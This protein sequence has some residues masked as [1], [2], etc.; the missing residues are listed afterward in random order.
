MAD[1][2]P[3][4]PRP[5]AGAAE[6]PLAEKPL[7]PLEADFSPP[8]P[9]EHAPPHPAAD[10][11]AAEEDPYHQ[12]SLAAKAAFDE[13]IAAV[14]QGKQEQA[15]HRFLKAS[16][17]A[18]SAREWY[19]AAVSFERIGDYF[20]LPAPSHDL[21]RALRMYQR[22]VA[23]YEHCGMF[24]EARELAYR[25]LCIKLWR[26]KELNLA[27]AQ[28]LE[29]FLYWA[30]AGFGLRPL[31]VVVLAVLL[32]VLYGGL[33]WVLDGAVTVQP[34]GQALPLWHA[35]Y[36]SGITFATVGYGDFIPAPHTRFLALTEGLIGAFTMSFFVVVLAHRLSKG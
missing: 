28:R 16:K 33:Y 35:I 25:V 23:A 4:E 30:V 7:G 19:L 1:S 36:F 3:S 29:H 15:A 31:R 26:G 11:S 32:I 22:A 17:L 14:A 20:Y 13:A 10:A 27:W 18:E 12:D 2:F 6:P 9:T 24:A 21:E 8:T 5:P 34:T